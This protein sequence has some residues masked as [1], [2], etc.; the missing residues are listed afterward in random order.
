M[1]LAGTGVGASFHL[2]QTNRVNKLSSLVGS[3]GSGASLLIDNNSSN[4]KATALNLQVEP[5]HAPM[6]V[7]SSAKVDRLN[8]DMLDGRDFSSAFNATD[9]FGNNTSGPLPISNTFTSNGGT[10][11]IT[12][13]GSGFRNSRLEGNIGMWV[14]VI[15]SNGSGI[16]YRIGTYTNERNSHKAFVTYQWVLEDKPAGTYTIRLTEADDLFDCNTAAEDMRDY[17]T[18]T[19]SNDKFHVTVLEIPD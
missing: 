6:R 5:G 17:C 7:S 14:N 8:A 12:A 1:A 10:L 3:V 13:S 15:D 4:A 19:D 11:L 2:G 9:V 16:G 18:T